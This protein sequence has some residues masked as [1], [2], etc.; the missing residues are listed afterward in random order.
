MS[1]FHLDHQY[2]YQTMILSGHGQVIAEPDTAVIRLGVQ[3]TGTDLKEVQ[4]RNAQISQAVL[5]ALRQMGIEDI[6]TVQYSVEKLYDYEN[7][8]QVD[9]G[10]SVRNIVEIRTTAIDQTGEI[11]DTAVNAGANIVEFISFEVSDRQRYYQEAL[12]LAVNDAIDKSR[13]IAYHLDLPS[14]PIPVKI[15]ENSTG[16]VTPAPFQRELAAATPIVPGNIE[17]E[18]M[19][20]VEFI[21]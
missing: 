8:V 15:I 10:Y 2:T 6:K 21:Y 3:T 12:N 4:S 1:D 19:V 5:D 16:P 20:T 13:S 18:A 14:E 9:R 17:I 7:G 11:I